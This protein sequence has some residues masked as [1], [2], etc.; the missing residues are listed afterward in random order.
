MVEA[1]VIFTTA[2]GSDFR[3]RAVGTC[4]SATTCCWIQSTGSFSSEGCPIFYR[5]VS[6]CAKN[7]YIAGSGVNSIADR[8]MCNAIARGIARVSLR[9]ILGDGQLTVR[10]VSGD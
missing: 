6:G 5:Y 1:S 10:G 4:K 7:V 8:G 3:L 2:N 9:N